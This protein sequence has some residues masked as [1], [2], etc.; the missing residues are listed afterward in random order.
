MLLWKIEDMEF[1]KAAL[2]NEVLYCTWDH[3]EAH[4]TQAYLWMMQQMSARNI[5]CSN[6][7]MWAWQRWGDGSTKPVLYK[8]EDACIELEVPDELVLLS[9]YNAWHCV[10]NGSHCSFTEA[11]DEEVHKNGDPAPEVIWASWPRIFDLNFRT[12]DGWCRQ[13]VTVQATFPYFKREWIKH[14]EYGVRLYDWLR[15]DT[16]EDGADEVDGRPPESAPDI[17]GEAVV[18]AQAGVAEPVSSTKVTDEQIRQMCEDGVSMLKVVRLLMTQDGLRVSHAAKRVSDLA[19]DWYDRGVGQYCGDGLYSPT[20]QQLAGLSADDIQRA[21]GRWIFEKVICMNEVEQS[22][23]LEALIKFR[24]KFGLEESVFDR[25]LL[26]AVS[27]SC[28]PASAADVSGGSF[29]NTDAGTT[30]AAST[31]DSAS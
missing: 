10:L 25:P 15:D 3:T 27:E 14:I 23:F 12:P 17:T 30:R 11:E 26:E 22:G 31:A 6:P 5:K 9:D 1:V 7:P 13:G 18:A 20:Y 24:D 19:L 4:F 8:G 28:P 16:D 2:A 21:K 29:G